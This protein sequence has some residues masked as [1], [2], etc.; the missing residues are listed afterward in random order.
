[1][2][3]WLSLVTRF[4]VRYGYIIYTHIVI[5]NLKLTDQLRL[6]E[7]EPSSLSYRYRMNARADESHERREGQSARERQRE[8]EETRDKV[9]KCVDCVN[10][11]LSR[12]AQ[13]T[14]RWERDGTGRE[15]GRWVE[16]MIVI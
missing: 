14:N 8:R 12:R 5:I 11:S 15:T 4:V 7:S 9:R 10:V 6:H 16:G 3:L 1:M 13:S 2:L